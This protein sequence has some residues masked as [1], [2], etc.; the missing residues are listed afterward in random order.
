MGYTQETV[1]GLLEAV[2]TKLDGRAS[3]DDIRRS[4]RE[5]TSSA[6]RVMRRGDEPVP[7]Q[8]VQRWPVIVTD[9]V[10]GG[11]NDYQEHVEHWARSTIDTI[12][13]FHA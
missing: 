6:G 5:R 12:D 13:A 9:I 1:D 7:V 4:V 8:G 3:M 2:H 11:V 10:C